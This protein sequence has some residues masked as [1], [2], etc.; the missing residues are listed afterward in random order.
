MAD[1]TREIVER[2]FREESGQTVATLIRILGDFGLA[3]EAVQEAFLVAMERWP[4]TGV[5]DRPGAW[6]TTTARNKA[7]DRLRRERGLA[8]RRA[9]LAPMLANLPP[10]QQAIVY[11]RFYEDLTQSEIGAQ[12]GIS[13]MHVSRLLSRTLSTLRERAVTEPV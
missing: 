13:Q 8:E 10:R 11:L 2:V 6:I 4:S 5:P 1:T 9:A 12:L 7:I 3:E